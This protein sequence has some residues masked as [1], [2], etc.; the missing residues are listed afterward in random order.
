MRSLPFAMLIAASLLA[1][2]ASAAEQESL[3]VITVTAKRRA[4]S[5]LDVSAAVSVVSEDLG[6][7][8][9]L[10]TDALRL[11]PG[12]FLQQTTPGQGAAIVRGTPTS[13]YG[14]DAVG[15][16]VQVVTRVP[17]FSRSA[18]ELRGTWGH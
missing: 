1:S 18:T 14:S 2:P 10:V 3:E 4:A 7:R 12:A 15:G 17:E 9:M 6:E 16:V 5:A 13:L 8:G 11:A